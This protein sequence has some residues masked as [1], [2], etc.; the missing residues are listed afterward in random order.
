MSQ[1][2]RHGCLKHA[3]ALVACINNC[4]KDDAK[5]FSLH[6]VVAFT[7]KEALAKLFFLCLFFFLFP[8]QQNV[9]CHHF[10]AIALSSA[11]KVRDRWK[12]SIVVCKY[13]MSRCKRPMM[14]KRDPQPRFACRSLSMLTAQLK[15][16]EETVQRQAAQAAKLWV[17]AAAQEQQL[18]QQEEQLHGLEMER[19][20]LHNLVQ[21]LKG[22]ICVFCH[23]WPV[24]PEEEEQQKGLEHLYFPAK[25]NK[26][27]VLSKAGEVS[28]FGGV[29]LS[30][31]PILRG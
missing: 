14:L 22:N 31:T 9:N 26:V 10:A 7:E 1:K 27:L 21:Q 11:V 18:G 29:S 12:G 28:R 13:K 4:T 20:H 6:S 2:K 8:S 25:D 19:R 30:L 5:Y 16:A 15:L 3:K 23:V 24:L 17:Q